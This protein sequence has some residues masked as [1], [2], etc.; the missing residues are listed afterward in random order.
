M[1]FRTIV[2]NVTMNMA[3]DGH[4]KTEKNAYNLVGDTEN[5]TLTELR[6]LGRNGN[7]RTAGIGGEEVAGGQCTQAWLFYGS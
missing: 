5:A 6:C 2:R 4:Y 3:V 1:V 7:R